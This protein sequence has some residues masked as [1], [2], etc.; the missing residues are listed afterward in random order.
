MQDNSEF[1]RQYLVKPAQESLLVELY[2]GLPEETR[3]EL[4]TRGGIIYR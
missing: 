1:L 3:K 2:D 4:S